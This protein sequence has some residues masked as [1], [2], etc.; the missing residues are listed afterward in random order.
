MKITNYMNR[1]YLSKRKR[2]ILIVIWV[3]GAILILLSITDLFRENPLKAN[4][5]MIIL[6]FLWSG[7]SLYRYVKK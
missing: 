6:V 4:N 2:N 5:L 7:F 3:L 1:H